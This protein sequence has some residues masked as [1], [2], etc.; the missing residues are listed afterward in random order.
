M[1]ETFRQLAESGPLLLAV[2]AAALAG[3]VSFLSPCVLPL[4]PGY[5][6]Y[7]TGL[8]GADLEGRAARK[9]PL[10]TPPVAEGDA[11]DTE[12]GAVAVAAPPARPPAAVKGRVLAGTLLFIAGFTAVFVVTAIVTSFVGRLFFQYQ[13]ALE[14]AIGVLIVVLG[15]SYLGVIPGLQREFRI[16]RLPAAGLLGAPV[17]GAVFALS[18]VPCTGPTL[19][20]VLG[21]AAAEGKTDRAVLLAVA[22]CLG[23]GIPFIVFGLG[24]HR[25]LGVFR[26][27]R[28]NSRW[29]TRIGGVLLILIG[30]ALVTGGWQDFVIWLKT[31]VG[32]GE[33]SI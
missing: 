5:L 12:A 1:G 32:P 20:A 24:F 30:L 15:L 19:G 33:V 9:G 6:S 27:V 22:Y 31:H 7:V 3:L 21:M 2:G 8:A 4:M 17:L 14:I 10:L 28:R 16:Q 11:A 18:W 29:V 13:R 25:L 26:A 23:L